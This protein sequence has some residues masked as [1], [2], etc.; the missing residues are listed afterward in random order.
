MGMIF[1]R[2]HWAVRCLYLQGISQE[3][4]SVLYCFSYMIFIKY[5]INKISTSIKFWTLFWTPPFLHNGII[6]KYRFKTL[7]SCS[8]YENYFLGASKE[9]KLSRYLHEQRL[10]EKLLERFANGSDLP[11]LFEI[12]DDN[13]EDK[14]KPHNEGKKRIL[15]F[16]IIFIY[17]LLYLPQVFV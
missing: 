17:I 10:L 14:W 8:C 4:C 12:E 11:H 6:I 15:C 5:K 9:N 2:N 1:E 13:D 16:N 3:S 7:H